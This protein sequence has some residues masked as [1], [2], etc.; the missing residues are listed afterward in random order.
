MD[1]TRCI[2]NVAIQEALRDGA[3]AYEA[4]GILVVP[5]LDARSTSA[6]DPQVIYQSVYTIFRALPARLPP[7][8]VLYVATRDRAGGDVELTWEAREEGGHEGDETASP[9]AVL[10]TGPY[11]DLLELA[12]LG[13][14]AICRARSGLAQRADVEGAAAAS[15]IAAATAGRIRRRYLFLLPSAPRDPRGVYAR[16]SMGN[17]T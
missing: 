10:R 8:A 2:A 6:G 3:D 4:A 13:L 9:E 7:A 14:E 1:E 17:E 11:G 16:G 15:P 12:L 5:H